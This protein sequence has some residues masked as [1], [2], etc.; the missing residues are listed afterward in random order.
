[1]LRDITIIKKSEYC[2]MMCQI[3]ALSEGACSATELINTVI[4]P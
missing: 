3:T 2:K 4:V 1:M